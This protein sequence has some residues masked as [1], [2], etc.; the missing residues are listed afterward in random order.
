MGLS[1]SQRRDVQNFLISRGLA[2][3]PL[4]DEMSD[5][6]SCDIEEKMNDGMSYDEA[7]IATVNEL[8]EDHFKIIQQETMETINRR[9][10]L[11]RVFT[12]VALVAMLV[13]TIFKLMHLRGADE[14]LLTSFVALGASLFAGSVS[15]IYYNRDKQGMLRV[16]GVV[17]GVILMILGYAFKI[18]HLAGA[19]EI[20]GL[21]VLVL[22]SALVANT[23]Y[24]YNHASG[25]GNLFTYLHEKYSPGIERFLL[26]STVLVVI[27]GAIKLF[28]G[29]GRS[30]ISIIN[31][32]A[33]YGAGLQMISLAW[34]KIE[35]DLSQRNLINMV[36]LIVTFICL[37][38]PMLND[39]VGY[40][41]R[42]VSIILFDVV[43]VVLAFRMDSVRNAGTV[44]AFL[45]AIVFAA[46]SMAK[47][48]AMPFLAP[49]IT[50][51]VVIIAL[52]IGGI[53]VSEK[54]S[55]T[56]MYLILSLAGYF[57]ELPVT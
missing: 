6:V 8:P 11:S 46:S 20:V 34:R 30:F 13:A 33:I 47:L 7:W 42:L 31:V 39:I 19:D 23:I 41:V 14:A 5:H 10:N 49:N 15:G 28:G 43:A 51:S 57:L 55:L 18:L 17:T 56:R 21:S 2:F 50:V 27:F 52:M 4:L 12:Y 25:N 1:E 37:C 44:I 40:R 38:L 3:K 45:G 35:Q 24:V 48:T 29:H 32:V 9:F 54:S 36:L 26:M 53:F 22:M 16:A